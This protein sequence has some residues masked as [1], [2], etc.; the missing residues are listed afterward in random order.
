M[1]AAHPMTPGDW[2][3]IQRAVFNALL[4]IRRRVVFSHRNLES[5]RGR[6]PHLA[7]GVSFGGGQQV[8][9]SLFI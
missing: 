4:R 2:R 3:H 6:F 5:R 1:L 8:S 7:A 9:R